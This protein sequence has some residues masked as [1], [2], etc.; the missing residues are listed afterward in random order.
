MSSSKGLLDPKSKEH[1]V[2]GRVKKIFIAY[3]QNPEEYE[4]YHLPVLPE[5]L[6]AYMDLTKCV[7]E[8]AAHETIQKT[9]IERH[10]NAI[11]R[12]AEYLRDSGVA[13]AYDQYWE[14]KQLDSSSTLKPR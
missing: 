8:R 6:M 2:Y 9:K 14:G 1:D 4:I 7:K 5:R 12:L 13:V 11:H 10:R 3:V